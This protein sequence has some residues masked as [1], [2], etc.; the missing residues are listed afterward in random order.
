MT[1]ACVLLLVLLSTSAR[2]QDGGVPAAS[3]DEVD[4]ILRELERESAQPPQPVQVTQ[5]PAAISS[6]TVLPP[7]TDLVTPV[8]Q[9]RLRPFVRLGHPKSL[10]HPELEGHVRGWVGAEVR[11][12][13][14][15]TARIVLSAHQ[16]PP[17]LRMPGPDMLLDGWM[18][19]TY[20]AMGGEVRLRA[21]RQAIALNELIL[22]GNDFLLVPPR[23]DGVTGRF[24][25]GL[26]FVEAVAAL[27]AL[28]VVPA[29]NTYPDVNLVTAL[30]GGLQDGPHRTLELHALIRVPRLPVYGDLGPSAPANPR[31]SLGG[32][33]QWDWKGLEGRASLELQQSNFA[34]P[35]LYAPAA[36]GV[37]SAGYAPEFEWA[38]GVYGRAGVRAATGQPLTYLPLSSSWAGWKGVQTQA[39][40]PMYARRHGMTGEMDLARL[41]N[42]A[43]L[44]ARVG[45]VRGT[46]HD[47]SVA[48]H[49]LQMLDPKQAWIPALYDQPYLRPGEGGS[50]GLIGHEVDVIAE[51]ELTR[52][53]VVGGSVGVLVSGP[54]A[55]RAGFGR[56][57]HTGF[58]TVD[59]RL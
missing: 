3:P 16:Q 22:D 2:A 28:T 45:L 33:A 9:M 34:A 48:F 12:T 57:G 4:A 46:L 8:L 7:W 27:E 40:D 21:G 55:L 47:L 13:Q 39:Y 15:V 37:L 19:W 1:R 56:F 58:L 44:W 49:R 17:N 31:L 42:V 18:Q 6:T 59:L 50:D 53:V 32:N 52:H 29:P 20:S 14:G 38:M 54:A 41:Q 11:P 51:A 35:S 24:R 10:R 30:Q 36:A 25:V 43:D 26:F 23:F 5:L